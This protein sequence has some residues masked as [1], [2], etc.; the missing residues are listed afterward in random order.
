MQQP[1]FVGI[2]ERFGH[3]SDDLG[4]LGA[5]HPV[6]I[7]IPEKGYGVGAVDEVHVDPE[8][9]VELAAVVDGDDVW[10]PQRRRGIGFAVEPC[11]VFAVG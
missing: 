6:R 5:G 1:T 3:R 2:V 4:D 9:A 11:P 8:L 7:T 10:M